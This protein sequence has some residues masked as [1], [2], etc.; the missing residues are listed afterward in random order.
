MA[1]DP[2]AW[3]T[4]PSDYASSSLPPSY[5]E[6]MNNSMTLPMQP[7]A[8]QPTS[9]QFPTHNVMSTPIAYQQPVIHSK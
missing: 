2:K 3:E 6:A 7:S 5:N 1:S 4:S 9:M 8:M